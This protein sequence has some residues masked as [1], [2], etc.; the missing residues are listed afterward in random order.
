LIIIQ[1]IVPKLSL[2][3]LIAIGFL[4]PLDTKLI[5]WAIGFFAIFQLIDG[6][7]NKTF[8]LNHKTI[9]FTGLAFFAIHLISVL[10]STNME[11]AWFDIEVKLSLFIF[12]ILFLFKNEYL[13]KNKNYVMLAFVIGTLI[14]SLL[15]IN[16]AF[17]I[18]PFFGPEVFYYKLYSW[19]HPSYIAMYFILSILFIIKYLISY[20][21]NIWKLVFG[22]TIMIFQILNIYLFQSKAGI[23][24]MLIVAIYLLYI[25]IVRLKSIFTKLSLGVLTVTIFFIVFGGNERMN[26]MVNSVEVVKE[27]GQSSDTSVGLRLSIWEIAAKQIPNNWLLGVGAGDIKPTLIKQYIKENLTIAY[28]YNVNVHNQYLE[29]LLGQGL[30]GFS[31]LLLFLYFGFKT[32][33]KS[34]EWLITSFLI[35]IALG[36]LPESM[37]NIQAGTTFIGFF[38]YFFLTFSKDGLSLNPYEKEQ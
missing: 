35:T 37:L 20:K 29:T 17:L 10:Y 3:F 27:T 32:A 30:V 8:Y 19:V 9:T 24:S 6:A 7:V 36:M 22:S 25:A 18:Y 2:F 26:E 31:L 15:M 4:I 1:K 12:P 16:R 5:S 13:I 33:I 38:Y 28:Q 34:K 23:F 21:R 14:A 11:R